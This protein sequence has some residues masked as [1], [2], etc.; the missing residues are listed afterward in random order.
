MNT[1]PDIRVRKGNSS[2]VNSDGDFVLYW[3][4]ANRRLKW[5]YSLDRA[6]EWAIELG[7]PLVILE[8]LDCDYEW[9]SDRFHGFI[10]EGMRENYRTAQGKNVLY[11]PYV[12]P[13]PGKG[14][15]FVKALAKHA[16]L[17]VTDDFPAFFIPKMLNK[18]VEK[19]GRASRRTSLHV[20]VEIV[21]SNGLLPMD[22]AHKEFTTA[23]SFRRF[24]QKILPHYLME[25]PHSS[26]LEGLS[27]KRQ[28][29]LPKEITEKWP[30]ASLKFLESYQ[31]EIKK[32]PIDHNVKIVENAG[33]YYPGSWLLEVFVNEKLSYYDERRNY[34]EEDTTSNLSP[35]LHFGQISA[36]EIFNT[37]QEN[38]G[39]HPG[40]LSEISKGQ[41]EGWWSMSKSAEAFLDQLIIWREL[42][43][44][45]CRF[46]R[47][48]DNYNSLPGWAKE[49]FRIHKMDEREYIY[50]IEQFEKAETRDP[51]WNAAQ[52]Q[53]IR[54]GKIHNYLRML[55][56]KKILEWS[57]TPN[58]ALKIMIHLNNKYALDGR[59]PNSY[60]GIFWILGR[61][62][63]AWGERDIFGKVRYMSSKNTAR[64]V[65]VANYIKKYS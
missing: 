29:R 23:Y 41:K 32:L 36:H 6:K 53:L 38:E 27:L 1:V 15:G 47:A 4:V 52:V 12:E 65:K 43:F 14:S 55:W 61:Y 51:L 49:T 20:L 35:Y 31:Q 13:A 5:N 18:F 17:I 11:Y 26:P 34:P 54:E 42:G 57:R 39:W 50:S 21:D 28:K 22:A 3:M 63:R 46:N 33:G 16:C 60:S 40:K 9:A 58:E 48:Y 59:D 62:D 2:R 8:A 25:R 24:L 7:K 37:I 56:G 44:N 19:P 10:I 30:S 64:K 45:M